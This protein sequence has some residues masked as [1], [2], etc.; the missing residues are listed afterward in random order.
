M[1]TTA[2]RA[3]YGPLLEVAAEPDLGEA[4]DGGW[5]ADQVLAHV[6]SVDAAVTATALAVVS[7][8]R[9]TFDN[10]TSLD[11][12]NLNRI[13][14]SYGNRARLAEHVRAQSVVMCDVADR[15]ADDDAAV[16]VPAFL[17]SNDAVAVDQPITLRA[18]IDGLA[19]SHV[20]GHTQQLRDLRPRA[21]A[22]V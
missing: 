1:D 20:P 5:N 4:A 15:L 10:R 18:L 22:A 12:A 2:L 13:I 3:A 17:V 21:S 14:D 6:L 19:D 8:S 9:P 11:R 16:M 7:G